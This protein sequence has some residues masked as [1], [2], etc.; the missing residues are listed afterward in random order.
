MATAL[1]QETKSIEATQEAL[2]LDGIASA[3]RY[4]HRTQDEVLKTSRENSPLARALL[5]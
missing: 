4:V 3:A 5:R 1:Y 2:G